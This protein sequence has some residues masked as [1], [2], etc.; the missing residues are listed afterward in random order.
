MAFGC[1]L[2]ALGIRP[3]TVLEQP[4]YAGTGEVL[5]WKVRASAFS[6]WYIYNIVNRTQNGLSPDGTR[7]SAWAWKFSFVLIG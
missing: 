4:E 5:K 1:M 7:A 6:P 2:F 3:G